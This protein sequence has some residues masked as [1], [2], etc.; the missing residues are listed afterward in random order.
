MGTRWDGLT[1]LKVTAM[2]AAGSPVW[3]PR[4]RDELV[5]RFTTQSSELNEGKG[6]WGPMRMIFLQYPSD[7]IVFFRDH[8][9]AACS[10]S[11]EATERP[12]RG[13]RNPLGYLSSRS[14]SRSAT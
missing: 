11:D 5:F 13:A 12:R 3:L 1:W 10:R 9:L 4:F 8:Q 7:P 6:P 14:S 2:R